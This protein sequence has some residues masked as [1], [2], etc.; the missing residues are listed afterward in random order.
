M[1]IS[2]FGQHIQLGQALQEY[3]K[4][5]TSE[6]VQKY[7]H[8]SIWAKIH[9]N[10]HGHEFHCDITINEGTGHHYMIKSDGVS[11]AIYSCFDMALMKLEKQ[12]RKYKSKLLNRHGRIKPSDTR[13]VT[14]C[15]INHILEAEE[16][17]DQIPSDQ[18]VIIAERSITISTLS[19]DQA[20]MIMDLE[21]VPALMFTNSQTG[22]INMIYKKKC[23]NIAWVDSPE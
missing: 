14:K 8:H 1:E 10:K 20:V 19:V 18:P 2:V 16:T 5:R 4:V 7:F 21:D 13:K 9:F 22:R 3:T 12:L 11:N 17:E 15:I 6:V 23:G